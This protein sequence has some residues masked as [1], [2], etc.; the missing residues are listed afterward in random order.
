[1]AEASGTT[2]KRTR[3]SKS[4]NSD[5]ETCSP[6]GKRIFISSFTTTLSENDINEGLFD[7]S[8]DEVL[9]ALTMTDKIGQQLQ[10]ILE[11][12]E[13]METKLQTMEGALA[14]ISSLENA[15]NK[16]QTNMI[17]FNEKAKKM[18]ETIQEIEAGLTSTNA[19]IEEMKRREEQTAD[20]IKSLEDQI[21]YQDVYSRREN[22]RFFGL[23]EEAQGI[24]N[25]REVLYKFLENE[26]ELEDAR[27]IEFQRVHRLGKKRVGQ[28]RPI[29]VRFLRFPER[30]LVFK[31]VRDLGDESDVKVY[32]DFPKEIRER[33]KKLW[34][35]MKKAREEG[36]IA[37]FDKREPD[38]LYI[39]GVLSV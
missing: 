32:A 14:Q 8:G 38:K 2:L 13:R 11:R 9:K 39:D 16:I 28:S 24:E 3:T 29:I 19:D 7:D 18:G 4:S 1:M 10:Q 21:L 5:S 33:R 27:N 20:K 22:L 26:L 37:F 31:N 15:I 17:S 34:P 25:T 30:E 23:P 6:D 35:K 36:K 12:L